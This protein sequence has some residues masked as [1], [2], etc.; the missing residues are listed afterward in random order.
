M[1]YMR[2]DFVTTYEKGDVS[3]EGQVV[4]MKDTFWYLRSILESDRH[5]DEDVSHRIKAEC[6][7]GAK[8]LVFYV[9]RGYHRS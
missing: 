3:L 9:A 7:S 5:I 1:E 2:C 6:R 4:S 8:H